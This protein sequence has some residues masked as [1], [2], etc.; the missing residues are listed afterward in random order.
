[1]Q[2]L[3]QDLMKNWKD[4]KKVALVLFRLIDA[5]E[6][7][8]TNTEK[9]FQYLSSLRR[10]IPIPAVEMAAVSEAAGADALDDVAASL[11]SP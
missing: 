11:G 6:A 5:K 4:Q 10:G 8:V 7:G 3:M 1:M 9:A 2:D